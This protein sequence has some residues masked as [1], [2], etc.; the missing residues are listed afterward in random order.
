[1]RSGSSPRV[2]DYRMDD[3]EQIPDVCPVCEAPIAV[4]EGTGRW[5]ASG[6]ADLAAAA[7]Y[8][9]AGEGWIE[10]RWLR[11]EC[12]ADADH[13]AG[14]MLRAGSVRGTFENSS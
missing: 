4:G 9:I 13:E 6:P 10:T 3:L 2:A 11:W 5:Y 1:V 7:R 14:P 8:G 12:S